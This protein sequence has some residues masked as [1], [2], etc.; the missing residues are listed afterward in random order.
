MLL[1]VLAYLTRH[2]NGVCQLLVFDHVDYPEAGTQ[3]PAG[4]LEPGESPEAGVLRET[5][6]ESGVRA[7]RIIHHLGNVEW[8]NPETGRLHLRHVFHL[9]APAGLPDAWEHIVSDGEDDKGLRFRCRWME[10]SAAARILA[11]DQG[12]YLA[13][14][15]P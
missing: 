13:R 9:Q 11:G 12:L 15:Q 6:E 3:V 1:K 14:L 4:S 5:L 2:H 8:L 10:V 7:E